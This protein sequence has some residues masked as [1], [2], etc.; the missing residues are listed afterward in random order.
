VLLGTAASFFSVSLAHAATDIEV[1]YSLNSSNKQVFEKMVKQF[2]GEQADVNVKL[3]A[4]D[5]NKKI[6]SA[7]DGGVKS[8]S[9]P[10]LVQLADNS[11]P[12]DIASRKYIL[13]LYNLVSKYPV[14]DAK[15][16]VDDSTAFMRDAK[17]RLLAFPYLVDVPVMYYNVDKFKKAGINPAQ[18]DRSWQGLQDQLVKLA[19]NGSRTCPFTTD[20]TVSVNLEN[21]AAV[22][23]QF[24]TT[25]DNGLKGK[26]A[27]VFAFDILFVRHLSLMISWVRTELMVKPAQDVNAVKRFANGECAVL[28]SGSENLGTFKNTRSLNFGVTG[29]PYYPQ[30]TKTPGNAFV[31]GSAFWAIDGHDKTQDKA[32]SQFL[33]WLAQPKNASLWYQ[34]TGYLPLTD[35]AFTTT[36]NAYYKNLGGWKDVVAAYQNKPVAT[37]RGFKV[38][39]Y[40]EIK[41]MFQKKLDKA[42]NGEEPALVALKSAS[43][44]ASQMMRQK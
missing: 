29:L 18:P 36:D 16:F 37:S 35:K 14:K 32:T 41:A 9:T 11:S 6:E 40:P 38:S 34:N 39:N 23:N 2:N 15:W 42:L 3:K 25:A 1:W 28:V 44:E 10:N 31:T 7:L 12:E 26:A 43:S 22:N 19:N 21:L 33:Q 17:G 27:P 13:P 30:V 8:K 4:F 5:D 20:Q 24:Y